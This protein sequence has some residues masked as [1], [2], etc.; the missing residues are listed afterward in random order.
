MSATG[1]GVFGKTL[2]TTN[3]WLDEIDEILAKRSWRSSGPTGRSHG[4][5]WARCCMRCATVCRPGA[6]TRE[7]ETHASQ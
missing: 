1:L 2:Q 4:M 5:R 6:S 3:I 7:G